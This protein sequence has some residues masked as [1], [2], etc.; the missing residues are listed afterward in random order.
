MRV[1]ITGATGVLGR[2]VVP[3]LIAQGHEVLAV[4]RSPDKRA[5]LERIG[6]RPVDADLF[7][8]RAVCRALDGADAIANLATAIPAGFHAVLPWSWR[9]TSQIRRHVSANLV[10]AALAGGTV[11][12]VVQESFAPIYLDGGDHWIDETAPVRPA[13]YNRSALDAEAQAQRFARAGCTGVI[14]RFGLFYGPAD[15]ITQQ[16]LD[17]VRRGWYPLFGRPDGWSS[18]ISH[19]D[20]A[21]AVVAALDAPAGIYNVVD[22]QPL[23]RRE[24]ADGIAR[25]LG[26]RP[27]RFLPRWATPLGG[28]V[29]AT[30]ARSLR[31]SNRKLREATGWAPRDR[32]VLEGLAG[33]VNPP[34]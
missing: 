30:L 29:G 1:F 7:D 18:W 16:L 20:A 6:A 26:A 27:P 12:R 25:L 28:A 31:I 33:I 22:D 5:A 21:A 13:R 15:P 9:A 19:D 24:I 11:Q 17:A 32:T 3:A 2:R 10:D 34:R 8:F 14:V 23:R 4:G